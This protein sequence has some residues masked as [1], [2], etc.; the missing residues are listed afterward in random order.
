MSVRFKNFFKVAPAISIVPMVATAAKTQ[1]A[2]N[3]RYGGY[4][5][6]RQN[7]SGGDSSRASIFIKILK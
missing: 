2:Q 5:I 3:A 1:F 7:V 4:S 6:I